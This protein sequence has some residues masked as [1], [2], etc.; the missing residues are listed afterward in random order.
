MGGYNLK[1]LDNNIFEIIAKP[2]EMGGYNIDMGA[3]INF[4]IIAK[5][6]EMGG[7]NGTS[8]VKPA[9]LNYSKTE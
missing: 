4:L 1:H 6:S 9:S 5:P 3:N 8:I 2:S 7:Y